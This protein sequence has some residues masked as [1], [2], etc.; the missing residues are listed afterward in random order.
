MFFAIDPQSDTAIYQ[1]IV[2][3]VCADIRA[4]RLPYGTQLPT[5]RAL[6]DELG[7]ARGTIKRAYDELGKLGMIEMTQGKG[8]FVCFRET[9]ADSRKERAMQAIDTLIGTLESL[10]FSPA[11][12]SIFFDLK[13]RQRTSRDCDVR[14]AVAGGPAELLSAMADQLYELGGVTVYQY[15]ESVLPADGSV[16]LTVVRAGRR[17]VLPHEE[18]GGVLLPAATSTEPQT[19]ARIA[20]LTPAAPHSPWRR[21]RNTWISCARASA[22]SR[23]RYASAACLQ[24]PFL[25][26]R[27]LRRKRYSCRPGL[28]ACSLR[29][30]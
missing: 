13:L 26:Q 30:L 2:N 12:M 18:S 11:E 6:A 16:D 10:S 28:S 27:C 14:V 1:Q 4:G 7:L 25:S 17:G 24:T 9:Q 29:L 20:R 15:E 5:V 21:A 23:R 8:T 3:A 22:T 19:V